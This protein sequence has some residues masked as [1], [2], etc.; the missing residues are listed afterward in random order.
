MAPLTSTA[1]PSLTPI[2]NAPTPI[3]IA[4]SRPSTAGTIV[5]ANTQTIPSFTAPLSTTT[6]SAP[7]AIPTSQPHL[8][9]EASIASTTASSFATAPTHPSPAHHQ[10]HSFPPSL[11]GTPYTDEASF[12][13][14]SYSYDTS[15]SSTHSN[16]PWSQPPPLV[17]SPHFGHQAPLPPS[18]YPHPY[19]DMYNQSVKQLEPI[20]A[21]GELPAPRPPM[22]YAAL[23]GEALLIAP[24]PHHLYVAEISESIKK[25]Y[26]CELI[27]LHT[28]LFPALL[29]RS[30]RVQ[31]LTR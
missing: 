8:G 11:N 5:E 13:T 24:L 22:S 6:P 25:R 29:L 30:D 7:V 23:I 18:F 19:F 17:A 31:W 20:L 28:Y 27:V 12:H 10:S 9:H 4:P 3:A 21:P 2:A 16:S 26:A 15:F 1:T 14:T